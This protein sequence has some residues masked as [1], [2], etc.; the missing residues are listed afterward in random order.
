MTPLVEGSKARRVWGRHLQS[1]ADLLFD[2]FAR[3]PDGMCGWRAAGQIAS[4]GFLN[5]M[6]TILSFSSEKD[7]ARDLRGEAVQQECQ[8]SEL[9]YRILEAEVLGL[10]QLLAEVK[11][12]RHDL[13]QK[14]D[15]LR[16]DRD[17]WQKLTEQA[18]PT[19]SGAAARR[20]C[21][22]GR[23]SPGNSSVVTDLSGS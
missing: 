6:L 9:S 5:R 7:P 10:R 19:L 3:N 18:G 2:C 11:A 20:T 17:H 8:D 1:R 4:A 22:C 13:R 23:A 12:N 16:R 14:M 21:F 15:D